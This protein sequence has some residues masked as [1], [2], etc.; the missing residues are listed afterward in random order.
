MHFHCKKLHEIE[1]YHSH[2][3]INILRGLKVTK[4]FHGVLLENA[5]EIKVEL[6]KFEFCS[7]CNLPF[8]G[9]KTF[10]KKH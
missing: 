10:L 6:T 2:K 4:V 9:L 1:I 5:N 7:Y 3:H 8:I